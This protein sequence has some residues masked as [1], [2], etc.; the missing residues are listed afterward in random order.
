M[1][2]YV[3][4]PYYMKERCHRDIPWADPSAINLS[5]DAPCVWQGFNGMPV[6]YSRELAYMINKEATRAFNSGS[7]LTYKVSP[8]VIKIVGNEC[9]RWICALEAYVTSWKPLIPLKVLLEGVLDIEFATRLSKTRR[10]AWTRAYQM[11]ASEDDGLDDYNRIPL[12]GELTDIGQ[13]FNYR[14]WFFWE[15]PEPEDWK[16]SLIDVP[17]IPKELIRRFEEAVEAVIP[18][19]VPEILPE[20]VLTSISSS[21]AIAPDGSRSKHWRLKECAE[22]NSFSCRPLK[23]YLTTVRKCAGEIREAITLSVPQSNSVKLIEKQV[24][25]ICAGTTYSAYG[26]N[27]QE[28]EKTLDK[29]YRK[30][31]HFFCRDL[32]KEGITKPRWILQAIFRVFKRCY[33]KFAAW[34]YTGIYDDMEYILPD[35]SHVET[36]RGHGLGMANA[37]TTIMQCASFQLFLWESGD[38][39]IRTP[40]ALFYN[41]DG[42]IGSAD[43]LSILAYEQEEEPLLLSLGLMKKNEKSYRGTVGVLCERYSSPYLDKKDS[44]WRYVRR[45]PFSSPCITVAKES[46]YLSASPWNGYE[47]GILEKLAAF[48]GYEYSDEEFYLPWW[49]GG[50]QKPTMYGVDLSF[51]DLPDLNQTFARGFQVGEPRMKRTELKEAKRTYLSPHQQIYGAFNL[52]DEVNAAFGINQPLKRIAAQYSRGGSRKDIEAF[53][54]AEMVRRLN[55]WRSPAK[56]LSITEYYSRMVEKHPWKDF[57]PPSELGQFIRKDSITVYKEGGP[58]PVNQANPYLGAVSWFTNKYIQHVI[59]WPE[60]PGREIH[61]KPLT[62]EQMDYREETYLTK[63]RKFILREFESPGDVVITK[64]YWNNDYA[65]MAV[66]QSLLD[67]DVTIRPAIQSLGGKFNSE[68]EANLRTLEYWSSP[69]LFFIWQVWGRT[70]PILYLNGQLTDNDVM[71]I[72]SPLSLEE[73]KTPCLPKEPKPPDFWTWR[74]SGRPMFDPFQLYHMYNEADSTLVM[75][76]TYKLFFSEIGLRGGTLKVKPPVVSPVLDQFYLTH[77]RFQKEAVG[78]AYIYRPPDFPDPLDDLS[79]EGDGLGFMFD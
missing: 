20:V 33:P 60:W 42:V 43:E 64:R 5:H 66:C 3:Y 17:D 25:Q 30:N 71:D 52:P 73:P 15:E 45:I 67:D 76:D 2:D 41:D 58:C 54:Q 11:E 34:N 55:K 40:D 29:F 6:P 46:W 68:E 72:V 77:L 27:P 51:I 9:K 8:Q 1:V 18:D 16:Y 62:V 28:F 78:D 44:Y 39:L 53:L 31:E 57:L 63:N 79:D 70:I 48:W 37:L 24:A 36:K 69:N 14:Y 38:D 23:G 21:G 59:P 75:S 32:T 49:A 12:T 35:G 61:F 13:V 7:P 47:V 56:E 22:L 4:D 50:W 65:V 26:L 74:S 19:E 10:W